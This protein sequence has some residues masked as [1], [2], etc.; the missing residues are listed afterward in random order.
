M[1]LSA[2]ETLVSEARRL[3]KLGG[4]LYFVG[5]DE[6]VYEFAARSHFIR[7]VGASHFFDSKTEAIRTIYRRLDP[8]ICAQCT[9]RVFLECPKDS[10][11]N[12]Q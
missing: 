3:Q 12:A 2:A 8:A 4:G 7:K 1:D 6:G 11:Q 10:A 5:L 9:A